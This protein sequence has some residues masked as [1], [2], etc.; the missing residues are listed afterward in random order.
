MSF[1]QVDD[2]YSSNHKVLALI[3]GEGFG[4]A[5]DAIALWTL[6]GSLCRKAGTDGVVTPGNVAR[7]T[8]DRSAGTK[9]AA[10]LVKYRLWHAAG[11]GCEA[12]PQPPDGAWVFHQWFQFR[13]G[14]GGAERVARDKASERKNAAIVEAVWARDTGPD[15][16]ARCRYCA[17]VVHRPSSGKGG[18]RRS[19]LIGHLDHVDPGR[20]VGATNIVVACGPCNQEKAARTPEAAGMTLLPP[21]INQQIN[22]ETNPIDPATNPGPSLEVGPPR[23]HARGGAGGAGA[24]PGRGGAVPAVPGIDR[25][26]TAGSES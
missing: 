25:P 18:D 11:H 15:G 22:P 24:G 19:K 5:G 23:A 2:D 17:T 14:T 1:F 4:R 20:A 7:L 10:L 3:E 16:V 12:C 6:A 13:Y 21:P 26:W 9:A 8:L